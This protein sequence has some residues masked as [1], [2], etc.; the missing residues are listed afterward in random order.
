[1]VIEEYLNGENGARKLDIFLKVPPSPCS[2]PFVLLA[3]AICI[4]LQR[5]VSR[6]RRCCVESCDFLQR[7]SNNSLYTNV[8]MCI[9][10]ICV[11]GYIDIT[12]AIVIPNSTVRAHEFV[13]LETKSISQLFL[14]ASQIF[15]VCSELS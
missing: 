8:P 15:C 10:Y 9:A 3:I 6:L 14:F 4:T 13:R 5:N 1:M 2:L 11:K 7:T 12:D